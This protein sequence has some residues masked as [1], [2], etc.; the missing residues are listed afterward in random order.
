MRKKSWELDI[1]NDHI[2]YFRYSDYLKAKQK[3][4]KQAFKTCFVCKGNGGFWTGS[5]IGFDTISLYLPCH[6]CGGSGMI[7]TTVDKKTL[8]S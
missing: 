6:N 5:S 8:K 7:D 3:L 1:G 4:E 2:K